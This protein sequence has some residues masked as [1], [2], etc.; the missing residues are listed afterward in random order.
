[1]GLWTE[2]EG[3]VWFSDNANVSLKTLLAEMYSEA[4]VAVSATRTARNR[5]SF[6]WRFEEGD[7]RGTKIIQ[8][9]IKELLEWDPKAKYDF[10][11]SIRYIN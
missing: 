11:A 4:F 8:E 5:Q 10:T 6:T 1:M 3:A 2:V 9:F 7:V